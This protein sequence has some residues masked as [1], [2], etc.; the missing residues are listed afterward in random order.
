M[1][2]KDTVNSLGPFIFAL[3]GWDLSHPT[4]NNYP[5]VIMDSFI[6]NQPG[7]HEDGWINP[8][9]NPLATEQYWVNT[10]KMYFEN[11]NLGYNAVELTHPPWTRWPSFWQTTFSNAFSWMKLIEFRFKFHWNLFPGV[12]IDNKP[13]FVQVMAWQWPPR[14]EMS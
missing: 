9:L 8:L 14:G 6:S 12:L 7:I 1:L 4:L 13:A 5:W 3:R 11:V 2:C 10:L